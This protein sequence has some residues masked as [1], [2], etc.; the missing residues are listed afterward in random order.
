MS[1]RLAPGTLGIIK[2]RSD[3]DGEPAYGAQEPVYLSDTI[4]DAEGIHSY[5]KTVRGR[6]L[7][8]EIVEVQDWNGEDDEIYIV[9]IPKFN[10]YRQMH[11]CRFAMIQ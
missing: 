11:C 2:E 5:S 7:F 4:F 8:N 10:A 9:Y 3:V 6:E 1:F